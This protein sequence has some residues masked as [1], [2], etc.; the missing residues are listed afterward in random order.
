M[1]DENTDWIKKPPTCDRAS[2]RLA[3]A[4]P[5]H[6]PSA[7]P[8]SPHWSK[9]PPGNHAIGQTGGLLCPMSG[10]AGFPAAVR[11]SSGL[12][13]RRRLGSVTV[14]RLP[15]DDGGHR[16]RRLRAERCSRE[17]AIRH[18]GSFG[19][20]GPVL[21]APCSTGLPPAA[22]ATLGGTRGNDAE[23]GEVLLALPTPFPGSLGLPSSRP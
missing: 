17:A 10:G 1:N 23:P 8:P 16:A 19:A 2:G 4:P 6:R 20:E 12:W 15:R 18:G 22:D 13:R 7:P 14:A 5:C 3:V 11:Y 9:A 21:S